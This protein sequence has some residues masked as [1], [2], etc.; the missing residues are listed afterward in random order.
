[1][2]DIYFSDKKKNSRENEP[3]PSKR[4]ISDKFTDADFDDTELDI[5]SRSDINSNIK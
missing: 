2:D 5:K 3:S 1:M 4:I